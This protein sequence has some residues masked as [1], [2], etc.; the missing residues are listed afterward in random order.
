MSSVIRTY[1]D[2]ISG[3]IIIVDV[4]D[5]EAIVQPP[6]GS[7]F[8]APAKGAEFPIMKDAVI[9]ALASA[10]ATQLRLY[11]NSVR[12]KTQNSNLVTYRWVPEWPGEY[13]LKVVP[14]GQGGPGTPTEITVTVV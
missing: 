4:G 12:V 13:K 9:E 5:T 6:L 2:T 8:L 1:S 11:I 10:D 3:G 14:R 7:I